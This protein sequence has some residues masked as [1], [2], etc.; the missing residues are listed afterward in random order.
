[1]LLSYVIYTCEMQ[2]A[3]RNDIGECR[4]KNLKYRHMND[5]FCEHSYQNTSDKC[6][7]KVC[8]KELQDCNGNLILLVPVIQSILVSA[9]FKLVH[10]PTGYLQT[11]AIN[12]ISSQIPLCPLQTESRDLIQLLVIYVQG[13]WHQQNFIDDYEKNICCRMYSSQT[14][15]PLW[16]R[17][18]IRHRESVLQV[19]NIIEWSKL[20]GTSKDHLFQPFPEVSRDILN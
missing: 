10:F 17:K 18:K 1:M 20:E 6:L 13:F 7:E 14:L 19:H 15:S 16:K 9:L 2:I 5:S 11:L 3:L 8:I 4:L 12:L